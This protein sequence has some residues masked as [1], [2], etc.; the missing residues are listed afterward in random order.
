MNGWIGVTETILGSATMGAIFGLF[1]GQPLLI[2]GPTGPLAVFEG[3][4][5]DVVSYNFFVVLYITEGKSFPQYVDFFLRVLPSRSEHVHVFSNR[6][7]F[8]KVPKSHF[9]QQKF[10][11]QIL[12]L[13]T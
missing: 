3:S 9:F 7:L 5:Y 6:K 12:F 10:L 4:L 2:V 1:S 13:E 8:L 11:N